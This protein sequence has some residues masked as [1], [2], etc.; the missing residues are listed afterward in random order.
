MKYFSVSVSIITQAF[1][2]VVIDGRNHASSSSIMQLLL[3]MI[4]RGVTIRYMMTVAAVQNHVRYWVGYCDLF[5]HE[6]LWWNVDA[7]TL[8]KIK[9]QVQNNENAQ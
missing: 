9:L 6:T 2:A 1:L 5:H 7:S 4:R 3:I 8:K